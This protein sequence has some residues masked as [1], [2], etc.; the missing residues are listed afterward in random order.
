M[1]AETQAQSLLDHGYV[2]VNKLGR[3]KKGQRVHHIGQKYWQAHQNGTAT[4]ERIFRRPQRGRDVELIVKMDDPN[5]MSG[6][7][8]YWA[9]YHTVIV[10][11]AA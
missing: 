10:E 3:F 8:G 2:E 11:E 6:E 7:Y 9:D 1:S 4:I 5:S